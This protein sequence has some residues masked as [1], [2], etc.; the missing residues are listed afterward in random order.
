M[1]P[2]APG[3]TYDQTLAPSPVSMAELDELKASVA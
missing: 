1:N 2:T 3:Y